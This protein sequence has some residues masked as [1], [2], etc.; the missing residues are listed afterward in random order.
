MIGALIKYVP[1]S[2]L[3]V[4]TTESVSSKHLTIVYLVVWIFYIVLTTLWIKI[5]V[6]IF[7][8]IFYSSNQLFSN[9]YMNDQ[10]MIAIL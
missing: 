7:V 4:N 2:L 8:F 1:L 9:P 3:P 5:I 6:K 10:F